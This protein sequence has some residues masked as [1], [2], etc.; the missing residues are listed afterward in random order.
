MGKSDTIFALDPEQEL[1]SHDG[2]LNYIQSIE[3]YYPARTLA[4]KPF[5]LPNQAGYQYRAILKAYTG[6]KC[7]FAGRR[8]SVLNYVQAFNC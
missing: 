8:D 3:G 1:D 7:H 4:R 6:V 2:M 5:G